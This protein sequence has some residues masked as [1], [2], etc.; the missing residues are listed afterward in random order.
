MNLGAVIA[1][2]A[3]FRNIIMKDVLPTFT[4]K[5]TQVEWEKVNPGGSYNDYL[6]YLS[7][8]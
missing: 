3:L 4:A 6:D 7:G 1:A 2:A 5:L 8:G